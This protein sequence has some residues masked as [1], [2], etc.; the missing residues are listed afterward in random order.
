M[1]VCG[2]DIGKQTAKAVIMDS[3]RIVS[4]AIAPCTGGAQMAAETVMERALSEARLKCEDLS[5]IVATG[6]G[7]K[8]VSFSNSQKNPVNCVA[9]GTG[10][11]FPS[12]RMVIDIG[13]ESSTVVRFNDRGLVEDS[14]THDRCASAS[15]TFLISMAQ[16]MGMPLEDMALASLAATCRVEI[17]STCSV[18][19]E[20]EVI[21]FM[22]RNPPITKQD[23]IAGIYCSMAKR[24]VGL[25]KR[26]GIRQDLV[27][28]GGVARNM[29]FI[30]E[31]ETE[32]GCNVLV[33][34]NPEFLGAIG[35]ALTA[36]R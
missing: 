3:T 19:A 33:P 15:G 36:S 23:L 21:S 24:I 34:E 20:Q 30:R 2:L 14:I 8:L 17:T 26:I 5:S 29:G 27:A 11:L 28:C 10:F 7:R 1:P 6:A 9:K 16:M 13:G 32:I 12:A 18:F 22:H 31:L 4:R 35:A 25:A